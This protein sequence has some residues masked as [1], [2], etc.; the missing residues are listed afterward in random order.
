M[1]PNPKNKM[2]CFHVLRALGAH[3]RL[4]SLPLQKA[5]QEP[6]ASLAFFVYYRPHHLLRQKASEA[7][8]HL[9]AW[10]L[11]CFFQDAL[12]ET[13]ASWSEIQQCDILILTFD[14]CGQHEQTN[15]DSESL[16]V[17]ASCPMHKSHPFFPFCST[18]PN[19]SSWH[20]S[21]FRRSINW[22]YWLQRHQCNQHGKSHTWKVHGIACAMKQ[23]L[24]VPAL[25]IQLCL[26]KLVFLFF[27][28]TNN[29]LRSW[30]PW[31][32]HTQEHRL[33]NPKTRGLPR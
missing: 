21:A 16:M 3:L 11:H 27:F 29:N 7:Q 23:L 15:F 26:G 13:V 9:E 1:Y 32:Q 19:S 31:P 20:S 14:S 24:L 28:Q 22:L 33:Q 30:P 18:V 25:Q 4:M 8:A 6:Y 10:Q 5:F 12:P 2:H 17:M